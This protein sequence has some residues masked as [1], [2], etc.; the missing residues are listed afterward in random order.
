MVFQKLDASDV[1]RYLS[2]QGIPS[3]EQTLWVGIGEEKSVVGLEHRLNNLIF[4]GFYKTRLVI[5]V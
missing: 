3:K 5:T 2:I 1:I 4:A